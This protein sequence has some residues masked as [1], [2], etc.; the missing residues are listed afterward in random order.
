MIVASIILRHPNASVGLDGM[1][2]DTGPINAWLLENV[3]SNAPFR[4]S[5]DEERPWHTEHHFG[6]MVFNFARERDATMFALRWA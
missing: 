3:G 5:V 4:D 6:Y 1:F 2:I